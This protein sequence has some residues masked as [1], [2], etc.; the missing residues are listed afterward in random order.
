MQRRSLSVS[1]L[2]ILLSAALLFPVLTSCSNNS[3]TEGTGEITTPS[4]AAT[5]DPSV[6]GTE[7]ATTESKWFEKLNFNNT[8]FNFYAWK[9]SIIE[10]EGEEGTGDMI[11]SAVFR[12]NANVEEKL[13]VTLKFTYEAGN[14][15]TFQAFC[16]NITNVIKGGSGEYDAIACYTRSA[17]LLMMNGVLTNML[18][19]DH[20]DF[21]ADC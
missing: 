4:A 5:D 7:E 18:S 9:Q 6:S 1:L 11:Q 16:T 19:V 2:L 3:V 12:R 14:S 20:L 21:T 15:S 17:S 10:Y 8:D 13:G